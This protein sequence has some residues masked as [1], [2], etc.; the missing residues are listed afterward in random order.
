MFSP[1]LST[2]FQGNHLWDER[3]SKKTVHN[4]HTKRIVDFKESRVTDM[5]AIEALNKLTERYRHAGKELHLR[6]LSDDCSKLLA[7]ADAIID[8]N[9]KEDP[10]YRVAVDAV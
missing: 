3:K 7:D 9:I 1:F 4:Y 5:S 10:T 8:V 6:H 2:I